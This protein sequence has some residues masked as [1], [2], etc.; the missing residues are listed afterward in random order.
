MLQIDS[1]ESVARPKVDHKVDKSHMCHSGFMTRSV[2]RYLYDSQ[3]SCHKAAMT[4]VRFI[5][6]V[7]Y[8]RSSNVEIAR[9]DKVAVILRI[10]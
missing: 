6:L 5:H 10:S 1:G 7:I 4:H 3:A 9:V 8:L 2:A